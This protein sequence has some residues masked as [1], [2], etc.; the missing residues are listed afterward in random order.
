MEVLPK[1][2]KIYL[3]RFLC[4]KSIRVLMR[5]NKE[6]Y[7]LLKF[8]TKIVTIPGCCSGKLKF[9]CVFCKQGIWTDSCNLVL[10]AIAECENG[11]RFAAHK[12][13]TQT[14]PDRKC[15][16]CNTCID[17]VYKSNNTRSKRLKVYYE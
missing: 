15:P 10:H 9:F 8:R 17:Y 14:I 16:V 1:D 13:H 6:W 5:V 12:T 11:H 3:I 2:I 7:M 4:I